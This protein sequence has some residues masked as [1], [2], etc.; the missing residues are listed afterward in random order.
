MVKAKRVISLAEKLQRVQ[1]EQALLK[2]K[3]R[4]LEEDEAFYK[5]SLEIQVGQDFQYAGERYMK[6]VSFK[7]YRRKILDQHKVKKLLGSKVPYTEITVKQIKV[8]F[9]YED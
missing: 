9:V 7:E 1:S 3:L 8:D 2:S 4:K 5:K 6:M